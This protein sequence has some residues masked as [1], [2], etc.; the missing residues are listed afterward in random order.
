[1][2]EFKN[3]DLTG[4]TL[5]DELNKTD[6]ETKEF[7]D[8]VHEYLYLKND[9]WSQKA[10]SESIEHIKEEFC[11]VIQSHLSVLKMLDIDIKEITDYWNT[12]HLEKIKNRPRAKEESNHD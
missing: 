3:I 10:V 2:V 6:E 12:N 11:D 8:A 5:M 7:K 9:H 1:M 4:L